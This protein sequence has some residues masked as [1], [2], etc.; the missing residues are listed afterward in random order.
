MNHLDLIV[1]DG[2]ITIPSIFMFE[3][4]IDIDP[5]IRQARKMN[6]TVIFENEN[7]IVNPNDYESARRHIGIFTT[8][9]SYREIGNA[10]V[11]YLGSPNKMTWD[12]VK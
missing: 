1:K 8:I 11:R 6:C 9:I 10:Y 4:W 5:F 2:T 7:L 3:D 12:K